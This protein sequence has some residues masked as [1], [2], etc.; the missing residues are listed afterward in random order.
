MTYLCLKL[1]KGA[2]DARS[3]DVRRIK[4]E[5]SGWLNADFSP[6]V[7]FVTKSHIDRGLMNKITGSLL[8]PIEHNWD[9]E[10]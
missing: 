5:L 4:E 9:D 7:P 6:S 3:D 8:C 10:Q 2:N 1:Q